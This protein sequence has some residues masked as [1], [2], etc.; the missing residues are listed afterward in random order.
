MRKKTNLPSQPENIAAFV[1]VSRIQ[2]LL[3]D[4]IRIPSPSDEEGSLL[5]FVEM[6]LGQYAFNVK[7]QYVKQ[8]RYN[9]LVHSGDRTRPGA[10]LNTHVDT[11]PS[12]GAANCSPRCRGGQMFGRGACDAK[13]SLAA[14]L[15][16]FVAIR[17]SPEGGQIPVDLCLTVGEEKSGDGSERFA[18]DCTQYAW[19]IVGEPTDLRI[20]N[21]HA[22]FV[23]L[24]L[25][26]TSVRSHAF[27]PAG[28]QAITAV[29]DL[30]LEI[31]RRARR[32]GEKP[33]HTFVH[34]VEG[35]DCSPFWSVRPSCKASLVVNPYTKRE[36]AS[37]V[38][39]ARSSCAAVARRHKGVRIAVQVECS[40]EGLDTPR[41]SPVV[42]FL[43][44]SLRSMG[45]KSKIGALPSWTDGARL[46]AIGIPTVVFGPGSLKDA[47]TNHEKV[48]IK[49][50]RDTSIA[51]AGAI[52]AW[53]GR[54][55]S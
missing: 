28:E 21:R 44:A 39:L 47:H 14:M 11:V 55:S 40:D 29:A 17:Q 13:G 46:C 2:K 23:E 3:A 7:R 1:T 20:V 27:E 52:L 16:A 51:I 12:D 45:R 15:L 37:I 35:G 6:Y 4:L 24:I 36:I 38:R 54:S 30:M 5:R 9:I 48:K 42:D 25:T 49:D 18:Q 43:A 19:A 33:V 34:W 10:L 8:D 31:Q 41:N 26:A 50:V 32:H 53:H 22:G